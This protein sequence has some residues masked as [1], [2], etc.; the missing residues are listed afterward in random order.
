MLF[1]LCED[2]CIKFDSLTLAST[3]ATIYV[4]ILILI[5]KRSYV[6]DYDVIF[7]GIFTKQSCFLRSVE[8]DV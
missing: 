3:D 4:I 6:K 8:Y 1:W 7:A 2:V 5:E